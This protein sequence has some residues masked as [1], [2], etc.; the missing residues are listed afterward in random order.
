MRVAALLLLA[1]SFVL[2]CGTSSASATAREQ[3][4]RLTEQQRPS[5][6]SP[7]DSVSLAPTPDTGIFGQ[8][9][10]THDCSSCPPR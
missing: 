3:Y 7:G 6:E 1:G 8:G 4:R 5:F 10:A 2:G 9:D